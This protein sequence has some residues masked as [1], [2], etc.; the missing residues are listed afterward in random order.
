MK[1]TDA[2]KRDIMIEFAE[3]A[4][5]SA[6]S[7]KYKVSYKTIDR[8]IK[9]DKMSEMSKNVQLKKEEIAVDIETYMNQ[10]RD[11]VTTIIGQYLDALSDPKKIEGASVNQL[12]TAL[13]TLIDKWTMSGASDSTAA[14]NIH[15]APVL[16]PEQPPEDIEEESDE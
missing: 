8:L 11:K 3:G 12:T 4:T 15:I 1:L 5:K 16:P 14:L 7:K 10:C 9:S 6:L 2:V 13:G